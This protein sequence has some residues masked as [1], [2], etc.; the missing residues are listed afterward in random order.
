MFKI[1]SDQYSLARDPGSKQL[2]WLDRGTRQR[3]SPACI[4]HLKPLSTA[5]IFLSSLLPGIATAHVPILT[6]F[7]LQDAR[8]HHALFM[9]SLLHQDLVFSLRP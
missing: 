2:V 5:F 8:I 7:L 4:D 6:C 9:P 1:L 3:T